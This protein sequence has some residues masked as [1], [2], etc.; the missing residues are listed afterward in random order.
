MDKYIVM[1]I[2]DLMDD[3]E[4]LRTGI[5]SVNT[6]LYNLGMIEGMLETCYYRLE[7]YLDGEQIG[8]INEIKE[9]FL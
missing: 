4:N 5:I 6:F 9:Q 8:I 2:Q 3:I 7:D 1:S